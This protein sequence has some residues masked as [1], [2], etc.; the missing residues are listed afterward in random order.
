MSGSAPPTRLVVDDTKGNIDMLVEML[1]DEY[2]VSVAMDGASAIEMVAATTP[3][4]I[5]LDVMTPGMDGL[6]P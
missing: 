5:L 4:L 6:T 1:S 2:E 3:D